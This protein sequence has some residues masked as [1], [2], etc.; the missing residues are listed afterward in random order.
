MYTPGRKSEKSL[1]INQKTHTNH[2]F[3]FINGYHSPN[4]SSQCFLCSTKCTITVKNIE[5]KKTE[6]IRQYVL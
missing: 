1:T 5:A 2:S 3:I 4:N 6:A